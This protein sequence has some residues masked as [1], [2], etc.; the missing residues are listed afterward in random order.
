MDIEAFKAKTIPE[1]DFGALRDYIGEADIELADRSARLAGM[2]E[3]MAGIQAEMA[4]ISAG[5]TRAITTFDKLVR[6]QTP[7]PE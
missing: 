6:S 1:A 2:Q 3:V 7:Q 4:V 5:R